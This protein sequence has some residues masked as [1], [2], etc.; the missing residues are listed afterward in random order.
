MAMFI[1]PMKLRA[2]KAWISSEVEKNTPVLDREMRK[3][4]SA[5]ITEIV[6]TGIMA[7]GSLR[8]SD[9]VVETIARSMRGSPVRR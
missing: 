9:A 7:W 1:E 4:K 6:T 5:I 8:K 2:A 3:G